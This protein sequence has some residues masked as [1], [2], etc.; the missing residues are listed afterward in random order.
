M[1]AGIVLVGAS[2]EVAACLEEH[3]GRWRDAQLVVVETPEEAR[4]VARRYQWSAVVVAG[5]GCEVD[6]E[7]SGFA[8]IAHPLAIEFLS[9]DPQDLP[10]A[11][12]CLG[13]KAAKLTRSSIVHMARRETAKPAPALTRRGLFTSA[14]APAKEVPSPRPVAV[15]TK[16][17][18]QQGCRKCIEA[19]SFGLIAV[20]DR[21]PETSD[22]CRLCGSCVAVCPTGALQSPVFSD[23]QWA[24]ILDGLAAGASEART[25]L[26]TCEKAE[27]A[28][29]PSGT[30][31]E[32]LPCIG[33]LGVTHL[34]EAAAFGPERVIAWCPSPADCENV[35]SA[36]RMQ[37][38]FATVMENLRTGGERLSYVEGADGWVEAL[39]QDASVAAGNGGRLSG[40]RRGD[41]ISALRHA[42]K[43]KVKPAQGAQLFAVAIDGACTLCGACAVACVDGALRLSEP[44]D[45]LTLNFQQAL[46]VGCGACAR[47]CPEKVL[48]LIDADDISDII[49]DRIVARASSPIARCRGCDVVLGP[50][51]MIER[52]AAVLKSDANA[53]DALAYCPSCK[54]ARMYTGAPSGITPPERA[55]STAS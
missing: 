41:F 4:A 43:D 28:T 53:I 49:A 9:L 39:G 32:R 26:L 5:L 13:V 20:N 44:G 27:I 31:V 14:T 34:T 10:Q 48:E 47:K 38:D 16:C 15:G 7:A 2:A 51:A 8:E 3:L 24:G 45:R 12:L 35:P 37:G 42:G 36:R 23:D 55:D 6:G 21:L 33:A 1:R 54:M 22:G 11:A 25:L 40:Q 29:V 30:V 46:C 50:A 18:A 52:L 17:R 19:C